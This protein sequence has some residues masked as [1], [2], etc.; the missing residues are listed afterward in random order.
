MRAKAKAELREL[1]LSIG[2]WREWREGTRSAHS[3]GLAAGI[4][5]PACANEQNGSESI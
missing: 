2:A 4:L 1:R 3:H 5:K